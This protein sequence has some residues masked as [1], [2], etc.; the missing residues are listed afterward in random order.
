MR[1]IRW[2]YIIVFTFEFLVS[3]FLLELLRILRIVTLLVVVSE[4]LIWGWL[5]ES[6]R[7]LCIKGGLWHRKILLH[8]KSILDLLHI[9]LNILIR[10]LRYTLVHL[11][12]LLASFDLIILLLRKRNRRLTTRTPQRKIL[13]FLFYVIF[14]V[15]QGSQWLECLQVH[16]WLVSGLR[17]SRVP[18]LQAV[19]IIVILFCGVNLVLILLLTLG[20]MRVWVWHHRRHAWI[21]ELWLL[22]R[23]PPLRLIG[24]L[25]PHHVYERGGHFWLRLR[26]AELPGHSS[27]L[28]IH[29]RLGSRAP[30]YIVEALGHKS[31]GSTEA[32]HLFA[33]GRILS[34]PSE[35]DRWADV[36]LT[37]VKSVAGADPTL[38]GMLLKAPP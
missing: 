28:V 37:K 2:C 24:H 4:R 25:T 19:I 8:W 31:C 22:M 34:E 13:Q 33:L 32:L 29:V 17:Q 35:L 21:S 6:L 38:S 14:A 23:S 18:R 9:I 7:F 12:Y 30:E 11:C 15:I 5:L 3:S 10:Y 36:I 1:Q 26:H 27:C 16:M 20:Q